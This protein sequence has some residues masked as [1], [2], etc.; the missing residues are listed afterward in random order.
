MKLKGA[1]GHFKFDG[2]DQL[3]KNVELLFATSQGNCNLDSQKLNIISSA[4]E[5][6]NQVHF[7]K[8]NNSLDLFDQQYQMKENS[9]VCQKNI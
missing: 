7:I 1:S 6:G 4:T 9:E 8:F 2:A 3:N 5:N